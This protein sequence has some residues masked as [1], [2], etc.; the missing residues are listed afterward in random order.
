MKHPAEWVHG[1]YREIQDP[2]ERYTLIELAQLGT[3]CGFA[4][5]EDF[6]RA[7]RHWV[8]QALKGPALE[9]DGRWSEAI[10]VGNQVFLEKIKD[11]LGICARYREIDEA[12]GTY[13][14]REAR[15]AYSI[16]FQIGPGRTHYKYILLGA[17]PRAGRRA[18]ACLAPVVGIDSG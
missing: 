2:P 9:R 1:G 8:E 18:R 13:S 15:S 5:V 4:A 3:L 6:R 11:E 14:L 12:N 17:D 16:S 10:A 7:H